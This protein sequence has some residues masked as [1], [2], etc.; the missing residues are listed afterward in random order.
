VTFSLG[1]AV[2]HPST[3]SEVTWGRTEI[4][5]LGVDYGNRRVGVSISD[6]LGM[7]AQGVTTLENDGNLLE[8][9]S[10]I[11]ERRNVER[12]VVGMPY[13]PDGGKGAK[14]VEVDQ[15]IDRLKQKTAV[16]I[17]TWDE[18]YSSVDAQKALFDAG[19]KRKKRRQKARVDVMAAR[20]MLQQYLDHLQNVQQTE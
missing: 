11:I 6:P 3:V 9:L 13:G 16:Q 18:S 1:T 12:V 10:E 2:I 4:R 17:D 19:M 20:L 15:F 8:R 14:A 7:I 5:I